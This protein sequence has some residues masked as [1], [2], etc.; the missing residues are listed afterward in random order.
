MNRLFTCSLSRLTLSGLGAF[1]FVVAGV[2]PAEAQLFGEEGLFGEKGLFSKKETPPRTLTED[3]IGVPTPVTGRIETL[4]GQ[5][6]QF[7]IHAETNTPS[8]TV[9]FL[10]RD[11]PTAGRILS[12]QSKP[13]ERNRAL[14]TYYADP[15]STATSDV[16]SFAARYRGGRYSA[17]IRFDIDLVNVLS[18][19]EVLGELNFGTVTVGNEE[20]REISVRNKGNGPFESQIMLAPPWRMVEPADGRLVLP[21]RGWRSIKV[22]FAPELPGETSYFLSMSRSKSGTTK[23]IGTGAEPFVLHAEELEL[24]LDPASGERRATLEV[25][26][27]STKGLRLA[28]DAS[29]RVQASLLPEYFA[30]PGQTTKVNIALGST[31]TAPFD[32]TLSLVLANGYRKT[33]RLFAPVVPGRIEISVPNSITRELI[34][35][36]KVEAGKSAERAIIVTN[37]GGAS[38]PLEFNIPEPF[39]LLT[40]PGPQLGPL[41]DVQLNIGLA[42]VAQDRGP[43]DVSMQVLS[44]DQV[45][46]LRLMANV[47]GP[48]GSSAAGPASPAATGS[49]LSRMRMTSGNP[50]PTAAA[51]ISASSGSSPGASAPDPAGVGV[52]GPA[53]GAAAPALSDRSVP[54]AVG[55]DPQKPWY[56]N[57][58]TGEI[59]RLRSPE[60]FITRPLVERVINPELRSP[61]DLT[62]LE[63]SSRSLVLSWT[64]P[65]D[66]ERCQF[67]IEARGTLINE[68]TGLPES[69]WVPYDQVKIDRID[70]LVKAE[71]V[72]LFASSTYELRVFTTDENGRSSE[73]SE[74]IIGETTLPMDW[75]YIYAS[76]GA[77]L[78]V[79]LGLGIRR[80][81]LN[82]RP[83][84]YQ[85]KYVDA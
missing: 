84:V 12:I 9:E 63:N 85:A 81:I 77:V 18:D 34:N 46:P 51:S 44:F 3:E 33:V 30:I 53:L 66:S 1:L 55:N 5:E 45:V 83:E 73:P 71:L 57:L 80:V 31:D 67:E 7:E 68:K 69:V 2:A 60:G 64:A 48:P 58:D 38:V 10:I 75:T 13:L 26:S 43:I 56:A 8:A 70:R 65:R 72:G 4:K 41:S 36:G 6:I 21:P 37:R 47:V 62:M 16:F 11:S 40:N 15:S 39:R 59:D 42:P 74:M 78:L 17:A 19:I 20:V 76:M 14:V 32:G 22:A 29:S 82:R 79:V 24:A 35:F 25:T 50:S 23:L 49:P 28:V 27:Q 61:E 52:N 54:T